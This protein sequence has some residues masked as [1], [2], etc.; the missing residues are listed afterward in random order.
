[1]SSQ[2]DLHMHSTISD[3]TLEIDALVSMVREAG[4]KTMALTDHDSVAGIEQAQRACQQNQ[5]NFIPGVEIS[6]TWNGQVIHILGLN[7]DHKNKILNDGLNKLLEFRERRAEMI[8]SRLARV[9]IT[10]ALEG[11]KRHAKG[12]LIGR[13]HFARFLVE[14]G[15]CTDLRAVFKRYLTK[16]NPGHVK[17]EWSSLEEAVS[18]I[19]QSGGLACIAHPGRYRLT[20]TRLRALIEEF[21]AAGGVAMEVVSATHSADE[22][23]KMTMF[24]E[25]HQLFASAGSDYHG[26]EN[27]WIHPGKIAPVPAQLNPV[28]EH[29]AWPIAQ[30]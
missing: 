18:W 26:P 12:R 17:G 10:N 8:A 14:E 5:I 15:I 11:A 21:I 24:C 4:V 22:I 6:V 1:M 25:K 3:G 27:R 23:Q 20:A 9:G 30:F 7:I 28:W 16:G 13:M 29:H 19:T 2:Y